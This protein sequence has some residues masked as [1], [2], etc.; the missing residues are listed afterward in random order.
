MSNSDSL[1]LSAVCGL[2]S[3]LPYI[4]NQLCSSHAGTLGGMTL[5]VKVPIW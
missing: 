3:D 5:Y 4:V 2:A 1:G